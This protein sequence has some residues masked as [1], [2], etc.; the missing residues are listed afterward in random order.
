ML[1]APSR[2]TRAKLDAMPHTRLRGGPTVASK[3]HL[4]PYF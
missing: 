2:P 3:P 1:D 4:E